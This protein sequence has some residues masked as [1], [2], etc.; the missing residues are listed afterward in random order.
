MP[1]SSI[2]KIASFQDA[3]ALTGHDPEVE[4]SLDQKADIIYR[5]ACELLGADAGSLPDCFNIDDE[6]HASLI[7]FYK[8]QVIHKAVVGGW[9]PDWNS[10][11]RKWGPYYL[12]NDPG[13]RL[14]V[15]HYDFSNSLWTGGSRL[16]FE[17]EAQAEFV[18]TDCIAL[19]RDLLGAG[20]LAA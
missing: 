7:A 11:T 13:F 17:T 3:C 20:P 9:V 15:V 19:Y 16:C 14:R 18:G 6:F 4:V 2:K 8:L 1:K 5:A 10:M 12:L